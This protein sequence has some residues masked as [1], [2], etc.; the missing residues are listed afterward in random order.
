MRTYYERKQQEALKA[1]DW[2]GFVRLSVE[3][4]C[5]EIEGLR[6]RRWLIREAFRLIRESLNEAAY[7]STTQAACMLGSEARDIQ[8]FWLSTGDPAEDSF[9][10]DPDNRW[11]HWHVEWPGHCDYDRHGVPYRGTRGLKRPVSFERDGKYGRNEHA[12]RVR[13]FHAPSLKQAAE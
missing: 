3:E 2:R 6:D 11:R 4:F 5:S 1:H 7:V 8:E 12:L 9:Y 10:T 13:Q